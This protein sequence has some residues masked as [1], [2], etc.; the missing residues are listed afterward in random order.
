MNAKKKKRRVALRPRRYCRQYDCC[1]S[2]VPVSDVVG[3][4]DGLPR[5]YHA[6]V[7]PRSKPNTTTRQQPKSS[8]SCCLAA[9]DTCRAVINQ[10]AALKSA[11]QDVKHTRWTRGG[12][13]R[14][15]GGRGGGGGRS[16]RSRSLV[17]LCFKVYI[18]L[19]ACGG[20]PS[21]QTAALPL[22]QGRTCGMRRVCSFGVFDQPA[23][24]SLLEPKNAPADGLVDLSR[25]VTAT[26]QESWALGTVGG[27]FINH[28]RNRSITTAHTAVP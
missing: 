2:T 23:L 22:A 10:Q 28:L 8:S 17:Y 14:G 11:R 5:D 9:D 1:C 15:G 6:C 18:F 7:S 27:T 25:V 19:R 13:G 16:A 24:V 3:A 4:S 12:G 20:P 26:T 21:C